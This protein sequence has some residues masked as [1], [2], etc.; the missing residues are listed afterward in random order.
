MTDDESEGVRGLFNQMNASH[1][2]KIDEPHLNVDSSFFF[3]NS[4]QS[5]GFSLLQKSAND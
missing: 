3:I 4:I 5:Q 1:G 2:E